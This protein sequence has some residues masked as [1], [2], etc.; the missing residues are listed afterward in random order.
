[1]NGHDVTALTSNLSTPSM[2]V[3]KP[4]FVLAHT[5]KGKGLG[6]AE[7]SSKWHHKAKITL[8]EV[9]MLREYLA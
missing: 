7:N 6:V 3:G 5:V 1:M 2:S 4:R 8:E 9:S